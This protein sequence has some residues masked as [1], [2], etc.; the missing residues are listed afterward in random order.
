MVHG[1]IA[2][3][4]QQLLTL[5]ASQGPPRSEKIL[6][7]QLLKIPTLITYSTCE[8]I[9]RFSNTVSKLICN[10]STISDG[11]EALPSLLWEGKKLDLPLQAWIHESQGPDFVTRWQR[12]TAPTLDNPDQSMIGV[13]YFHSIEAAE[14]WNEN[15]CARIRLNQALLDLVEYTVSQELLPVDMQTHLQ[16]IFPASRPVINEMLNGICGSIPFSLHRINSF[17]R[18]CTD[19]SQRV[20]GCAG[21]VWPLEVVISC[22]YSSEGH[23]KLAGDALREIGHD[24]G[25]RQALNVIGH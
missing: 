6:I 3:V 17:G 13:E 1:H 16:T 11:E 18:I 5:H 14:V 24:I 23:R 7:P 20:V 2:H 9:H 19:Q 25:V 15:R 10:N 12:F 22:S 4:A 21:L 8:A